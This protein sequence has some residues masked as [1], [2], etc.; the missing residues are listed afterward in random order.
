MIKSP[1]VTLAQ[2]ILSENTEP[3]TEAVTVIKDEETLIKAIIKALP[4]D[5]DKMFMNSV[6]WSKRG[7]YAGEKMIDKIKEK[8]MA[9]GFKK[10][11]VSGS[12]TPDGST[13][14]F[15]EVLVHK[16]GWTARLSKSYGVTASSNN[17][18]VS[19]QKNK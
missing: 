13:I 11:G 8:L 17:Y 4:K 3:V 10:G 2:S 7:G 18:S 14:G 9:I 12:N 16:L 5:A 1:L 15:G 19:V 6:Y